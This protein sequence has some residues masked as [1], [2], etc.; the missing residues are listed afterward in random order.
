MRGARGWV[1]WCW[2]L[3]ALASLGLWLASGWWTAV[4]TSAS[5]RWAIGMGEGLVVIARLDQPEKSR[6]TPGSW[7]LE[8][9]P[10]RWWWRPTPSWRTPSGISAG[11][12]LW[13]LPALSLACALWL[14][15]PRRRRVGLCLSCGYD[16]ARAAGPR[17]PECG[18]AVSL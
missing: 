16:L 13:P 15:L 18:S 2:A 7:R 3:A 17:C 6:S 8:R 10:P 4:Y 9:W 1:R 11:L 12:P 14:W 5:K